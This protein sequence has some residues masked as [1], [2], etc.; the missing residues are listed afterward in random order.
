MHSGIN[1]SPT[2]KNLLTISFILHVHLNG[3]AFN[4]VALQNKI[5]RNSGTLLNGVLIPKLLNSPFA[6]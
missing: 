3:I 1:L 6:S 5:S 4:E 2:K